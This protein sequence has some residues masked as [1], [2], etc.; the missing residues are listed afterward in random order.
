MT[1]LV[2]QFAG[3]SAT[4]PSMLEWLRLKIATDSTEDEPVDPEPRA[5]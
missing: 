5:G 4:L 1:I 3:G 2:D